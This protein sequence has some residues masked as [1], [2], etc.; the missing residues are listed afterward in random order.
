MK[1]Q[2]QRS[3]ILALL[4]ENP[5]G[6]NSFTFRDKFIQLP[7]R[8]KELKEQGYDIASITNP[9]RSVDYVLQGTPTVEKK[10]VGW[11]FEG[12]KAIPVYA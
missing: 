9:D 10:R 8:I 1:T 3:K 2:T 4:Q 5:A 7:V 12:D 11:K 6:I